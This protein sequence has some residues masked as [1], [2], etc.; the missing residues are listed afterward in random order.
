MVSSLV[1]RLVGQFVAWVTG[2]SL[3]GLVGWLVNFLLSDW[4][5]VPLRWVS[6]W[7]VSTSV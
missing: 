4:L 6:D 1:R 5:V 2:W 7:L 3:F